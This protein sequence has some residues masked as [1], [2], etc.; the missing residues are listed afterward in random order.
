MPS[1]GRKRSKSS[2]QKKADWEIEI[3]NRVAANREKT[4]LEEEEKKAKRLEERKRNDEIIAKS[5][6]FLEESKITL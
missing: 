1:L 4:R 3:E 5:Q 6:R 2:P